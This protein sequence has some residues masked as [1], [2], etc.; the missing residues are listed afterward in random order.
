MTKG[1]ILGENKFK[2]T[3]FHMSVDF[4]HELL[5][6]IHCKHFDV[7]S[8]IIVIV[9][10]R[11]IIFFVL[12]KKKKNLRCDPRYFTFLMSK[13]NEPFNQVRS[14]VGSISD[15]VSEKF[16]FVTRHE[17]SAEKMCKIVIISHNSAQH[18]KLN[19]CIVCYI[20]SHQNS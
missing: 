9:P 7:F 15:S 6:L 18:E 11:N 20:T 3:F 12:M 8:P 5:Y 4:L 17:A 1:P 2:T 14:T 10:S 19:I 13:S 16:H